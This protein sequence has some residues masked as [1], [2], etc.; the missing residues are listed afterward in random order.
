MKHRFDFGVGALV[1]VVALA[2]SLE[3]Q[4]L[5]RYVRFEQNGTVRWGHLAGE[6]I[7]PLT[8]A[9]YLGGTMVPGEAIPVGS[10]TLKAPV[11]PRNVYMT[12]FNFRSHI[13]GEPAEYPGIFMVPAESIIGPEED[14]I[15]PPD[16]N[17]FHYEAELVVVIGRDADNVSV[18]DAPNYIFGVT[19]G[20]DGS[21]RDWQANDTQWVRAKGSKTFNAVGPVLVAGA[22]YQNLQIEGRLN[23]ELRQSENSSDM[24]FDFNE[25]VS[26]IS[27]YFPLR[28]GDL[29]WSGT[30]G[31]TQ[32]M[33]PGDVYE[34]E[35]E[36]VGVLRN[37]LVQAE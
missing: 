19:A 1:A 31:T 25:M 22:D 12:A 8:D 4:E 32:A 7:H 35:V 16:S 2:G 14:I 6:T 23:G 13:T 37:R 11:D 21:E 27:R 15:R 24:L 29:I 36:G 3:A 26:Y 20:N 9:P 28:A 10:V 18:E 17:N 33:Q 5:Q 30:M 34:V